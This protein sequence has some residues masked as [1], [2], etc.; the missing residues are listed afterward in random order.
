MLRFIFISIIIKINHLYLLSISLL[1]ILKAF[2][3]YGYVP[4]LSNVCSLSSSLLL[5][6]ILLISLVYTQ[7]ALLLNLCWDFSMTLFSYKQS[8]ESLTLSILFITHY[9]LLTAKIYLS[10]LFLTS[11]E[12]SL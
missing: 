7:C 8:L 6:A 12:I 3:R 1:H 11:S 4:V 9:G 10:N 2:V 5:S